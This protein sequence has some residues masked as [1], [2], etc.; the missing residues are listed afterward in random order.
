[1]RSAKT[2]TKAITN[3]EKLSRKCLLD[4]RESRNHKKKKNFNDFTFKEGPRKK[5]TGRKKIKTDLLV[6]ALDLVLAKLEITRDSVIYNFFDLCSGTTM[7]VLNELGLI[8][9]NKQHHWSY[10]E[11]DGYYSCCICCYHISAFVCL[12]SCLLSK[13]GRIRAHFNCFGKNK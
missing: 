6:D 9:G 3:F 12:L 7:S 5:A 10:P 11:K 13:N 8:K 1:M 2:C 4:M